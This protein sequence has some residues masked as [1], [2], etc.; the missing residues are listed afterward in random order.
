MQKV[1]LLLRNN[2]QNGPYNLE[3]LL[4]FNLKPIDLIW[5]EGKSAG[6][7]YPQEIEA[8]RPHLSF[9]KPAVAPQQEAAL[10][11][12]SLSPS[13]SNASPKKV[14]V[15]MP[16][17][18]RTEPPAKPATDN[19][20]VQ[21][22]AASY[23]TASLGKNVKEPDTLKTTYAKSLE[24]VETDYTNW[25]YQKKTKKT[26]VVSR[27]GLIAACLLVTVAFA[28][29]W[30][31]KP[32]AIVSNPSTSISVTPANG[33]VAADSIAGYNL[34][35]EAMVKPSIKKQKAAKA[36]TS[37]KEKSLSTQLAIAKQNKEAVV[38]N[39]TTPANEY[40]GAVTGK[41]KS[42][43]TTKEK[44][45]QPVAEAPKEQKKKLKDK[46]LDLFKK[47]K[48]EPVITEA[49]PVQDDNGERRSARREASADLAMQV[50]IKFDVPN[51]WMMGIKAAKASFTNH[52]DETITRAVVQVV[53]YN[54]DNDIVDKR[55]I[56][57][58]N[59][60]ANKTQTVSIPDH[61]VGDH[62]DYKIV[63]VQGSGEPVA[64]F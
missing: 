49:K 45:A 1:Y 19:A 52:S 15:S 38:Q 16:A 31:M 43:A 17:N 6:W 36:L 34:T 13:V 33:P 21:P 39:T 7:Y 42:A 46:F 48:D 2:Q 63:S 37:P 44:E 25:V 10:L 57:F 3:E 18:S 51:D 60:G 29:W 47:K 62:L 24:E 41:E 40:E 55:T 53:Y 54:E 58:S 56:Y 61:A 32:S 14:F 9:I 50:S 5:I 23:A 26:S 64:G 59:V 30:L 8:V 27:K 28:A 11:T 35:N 4:Q 12:K 22:A 20:S